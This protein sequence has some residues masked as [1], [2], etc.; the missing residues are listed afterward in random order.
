M[1][2]RCVET[3]TSSF[4]L[5]SVVHPGLVGLSPIVIEV[6]H[7]LILSF[8]LFN[9]TP[10]VVGGRNLLPDKAPLYLVCLTVKA[11]LT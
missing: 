5:F 7:H 1:M 3:N 6:H 9:G 2:W 11:M 4:I 10:T 8:L